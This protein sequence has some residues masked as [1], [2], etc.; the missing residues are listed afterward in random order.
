MND[1]L[2]STVEASHFLGISASA[3]NKSRLIPGAGPP[4]VK[5]GVSVR[6]RPGDLDAWVA[7]RVCTSTTDSPASAEVAQ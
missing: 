1:R 4:F 7:S 2:L 3:L 5:I 6:Y